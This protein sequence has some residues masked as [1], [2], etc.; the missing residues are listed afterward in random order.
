MKQSVA[1]ERIDRVIEWP[2]VG[3]GHPGVYA[4]HPIRNVARISSISR[5]SNI[6]DRGLFHSCDPFLACVEIDQD[7]AGTEGY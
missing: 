2:V 3:R 7:H 5:E 6:R 4:G 1:A